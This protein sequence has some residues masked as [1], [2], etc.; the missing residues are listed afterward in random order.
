MSWKADAIPARPQISSHFV[1]LLVIVFALWMATI[2]TT[3]A[4]QSSDLPGPET[5]PDAE[6]GMQIYQDRCSSCHG[7]FG[8]G[9]GEMLER[10][11]APPPNF[12]DPAFLRQMAPDEHFEVITNGRLDKVMPPWKDSLS[13]QE[14][15]DALYAAW[16]F[17]YTPDPASGRAGDLGSVFA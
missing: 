3:V 1:R 5:P 13:V 10:L 4:A 9:R 16:S 14:R 12:S 15:W 2:P 6:A 17:Y 7:P 8:A 11:P